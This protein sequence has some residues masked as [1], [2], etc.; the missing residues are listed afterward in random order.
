VQVPRVVGQDTEQA[1]SAIERAGLKGD[2]PTVESVET[3]GTV[4]RTE[5][6]MRTRL[7]LGESVVLY[8]SRGPRE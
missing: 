7:A 3:R 4:V 6:E 2:T 5:P 1:R 8:I